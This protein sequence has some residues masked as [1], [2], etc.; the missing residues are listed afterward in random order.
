[1]GNPENTHLARVREWVLLRIN[2]RLR[3]PP[4]SRWQA[5][6]PDIMPGL[7]AQ[8][9]WSK[10]E[11]GFEWL[12]ELEANSDA[13]RD[14]LLTLRG[15]LGFQPYRQPAWSTNLAAKDEVC[16]HR[17]NTSLIM[18][19]PSSTSN[20]QFSLILR[21]SRHMAS[22]KCMV[23]GASKAKGQQLAVRPFRRCMGLKLLNLVP[24]LP[25]RTALPNRPS[26]HRAAADWGGES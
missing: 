16:D 4:Q 12:S 22:L 6:C 26:P 18:H 14:E 11:K 20:S 15:S 2:S 13:I 23:H 19:P 24:R 7:R 3:A 1:M 21:G 9:F 17:S 8:P 25:V 5:G 10:E